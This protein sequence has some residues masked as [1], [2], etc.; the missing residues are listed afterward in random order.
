MIV[1]TSMFGSTKNK[2]FLLMKNNAGSLNLFKKSLK[3]FNPSNVS[4]ALFYPMQSTGLIVYPYFNAN[5]TKPFLFF[6]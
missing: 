3:D 5:F 1:V 4:K 6:K 2:Y